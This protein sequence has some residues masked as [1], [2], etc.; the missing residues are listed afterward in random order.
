MLGIREHITYFRYLLK[1]IIDKKL[2]NFMRSVKIMD[3]EQ[4][5]AYIVEKGLSVSRFGDGE[6]AIMAGSS[7]G[8]QCKNPHL[9][10]RL[11]E[12]FTNHIPG[13]LVCI[14]KTLKGWSACIFNS[15]LSAAGYLI[16]YAKKV[17]IPHIDYHYLYGDSLFTRF[18]IVN[19]DKSCCEGYVSLLKKLW[20]GQDLLFVEGES[21]RLGIGND[22]FDNANSIERI[23]CPNENAYDKYDEIFRLTLNHSD[24]KL[25]ILALGMTAT[26]L[27]YDLCK[28]GVRALDLGHVD[29]EY[30]WMRMGAKEKCVPPY[31][32]VAEVQGGNCVSDLP[33]EWEKKYQMQIINNLSV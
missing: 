32:K 7:N 4:T 26:V 11:E 24:G 27:A 2:I 15:R 17:V 23:L 6:F 1:I 20:E 30:E 29:I 31:K 19:K 8:F 33:K 21:T 16:L 14:P 18:Y 13:H 28:N 22:L 3:S 10:Q 12:V 9:A 25:V 5:V